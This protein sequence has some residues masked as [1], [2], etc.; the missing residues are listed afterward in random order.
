[1]SRGGAPPRALGHVLHLGGGPASG[2]RA[3]W[4]ARGGAGDRGLHPSCPWCTRCGGSRSASSSGMGTRTRFPPKGGVHL[5]GHHGT[6]AHCRCEEILESVASEAGAQSRLND[7]IDSVVRDQVSSSELI[8]L[9]RSASWEVPKEDVLEESRRSGRRSSRK[10]HPRTEEITRTILPRPGR[11]SRS[12]ASNW[13]MCAS[14]AS[15][16]WRACMPG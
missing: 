4:P 12:M 5:G 16:T 10:D 13:W 7:I 3:V 1:M 14:N 9:V 15:T 2:H 8:E 11:S 6:L